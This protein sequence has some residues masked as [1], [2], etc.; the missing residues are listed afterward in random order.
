MD[1][2]EEKNDIK[3]VQLDD[4]TDEKLKPFIPFV[5]DHEKG[6]SIIFY[7]SSN[8]EGDI[9]I[10]CGFSKLFNEIET[11]GTYRYVLNSISCKTQ[12]SKRTIEN[13]FSWIQTFNLD[14]FS[15]DIIR[16]ANWVF[17]E[18]ISKDFYIIYLIDATGSMGSEIKAAKE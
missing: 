7:P 11:N 12:F 15:Y 13:N 1:L 10:D 6:L 4:S 16:D 9:I 8:K 3:E 14:S 2:K 17:R 5:Y 18:G